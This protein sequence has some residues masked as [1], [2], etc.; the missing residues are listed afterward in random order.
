MGKNG[1]ISV[2]GTSPLS[3]QPSSDEP[4]VV[5]A[6]YQGALNDEVVGKL[7]DRES[8][9][10]SEFMT[11]SAAVISVSAVVNVPP[12]EAE[13]WRELWESIKSFVDAQLDDM[14]SGMPEPKTS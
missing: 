9:F 12:S 3:D 4:A 1:R 2:C 13:D 11:D 10:W 6:L 5:F 14:A 7:A 8:D